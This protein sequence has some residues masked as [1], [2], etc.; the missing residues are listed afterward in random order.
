M[1]ERFD[2][3]TLLGQDS[4]GSDQGLGP[5]E[6]SFL[7][8]PPPTRTSGEAERAPLSLDQ[9]SLPRKKRGET[10]EEGGTPEGKEHSLLCFNAGCSLVSCSLDLPDPCILQSWCLL[11]RGRRSLCDVPFLQDLLLSP[12]GP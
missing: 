10:Q 9:C 5:K 3:L 12:C 11:G 7:N 1:K 8:S 6:K 2:T 4:E